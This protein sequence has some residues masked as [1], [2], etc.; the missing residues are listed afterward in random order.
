M[1]G[2]KFDPEKHPVVG[3]QDEEIIKMGIAKAD[4]ESIVSSVDSHEEQEKEATGMII[5][6]SSFSPN[7]V[8]YVLNHN[9]FSK[10]VNIL[11]V[12]NEISGAISYTGGEI[13]DE[14]RDAARAVAE[15]KKRAAKVAYEIKYPHWYSLTSTMTSTASPGVELA[16]WKHSAIS[17]GKA[18]IGFPN[19]SKHSSHGFTMANVKWYRRTNTW[20]QDSITYSWHCDSKYKANRMTLLKQIGNTQTVIARYAQ[21]WGSW[22]TGGVLLVDDREVDEV[23]AVLTTCVMLKRMQQRAAER[24]KSSGGGGGGGGS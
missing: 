18:E 5:D 19:D 12:T 7:Q 24:T 2:S 8:F 17:C 16:T 1:K 14:F 10:E 13:R 22:V 3:K 6:A 23:V 11:N 4:T 9:L 20:V 21:R 15:D